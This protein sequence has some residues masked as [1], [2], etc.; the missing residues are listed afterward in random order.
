MQEGNYGFMAALDKFVPNYGRLPCRLS[1][2]HHDD[3]STKQQRTDLD[4]FQ[5][6][7]K[8]IT[9]SESTEAWDRIMTQFASSCRAKFSPIQAISGA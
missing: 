1:K 6:L 2:S 8:M 3:N 7:V 9:K 4:R 5:S